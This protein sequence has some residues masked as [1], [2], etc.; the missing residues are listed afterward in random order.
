MKKKTLFRLLLVALVASVACL[1]FVNSAWSGA[2]E[3]ALL[4]IDLQKVNTPQGLAGE[5]PLVK[6]GTEHKVIPNCKK[7]LEIARK[8]GVF[9][10]HIRVAYPPGT[11]GAA[12]TGFW[13]AI[14]ALGAHIEGT[15]NAEI[16]DELRP[17]PGLREIVLT[18]FRTSSFY[19]TPLHEILTHMGIK[20]V[21]VTGLAVES[22]VHHTI[23][24]AVD[25]GYHTIAVVRECLNAIDDQGYDEFVNHVWPFHFVD[26]VNL[27]DLEDYIDKPVVP[28]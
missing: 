19:G 6:W 26:I 2:E 13:R 28:H 27:A 25:H 11:P 24:D 21:I 22:C 10:V 5:F 15:W 12:A 17:K 3:T 7:A 4:I 8:K 20:K 23:M 14:P 1:G 18:K 16:V 9:I